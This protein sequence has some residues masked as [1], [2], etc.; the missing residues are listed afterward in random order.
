MNW[1]DVLE[2]IY[3]N[4]DWIRSWRFGICFFVGV[5][6]AFLAAGHIAAHPLNWIVGGGIVAIA[7]YIGNRWESSH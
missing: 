2:A 3:E 7:I 1:R 4:I 6:L 5:G